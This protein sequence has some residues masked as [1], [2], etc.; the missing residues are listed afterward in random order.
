MAKFVNMTRAPIHVRDNMMIPGV[1]IDIPD[2]DIKGLKGFKAMLDAKEV[3]PYESEEARV[4]AAQ[5]AKEKADLAAEEK[6]AKDEAAAKLAQSQQPAAPSAPAK[7]PGSDP[8]K[9]T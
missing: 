8:T 7:T 9:G 1:E 5:V 3:V 4:K 6:R 2:E